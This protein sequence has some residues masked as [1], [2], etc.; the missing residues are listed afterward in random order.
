MSFWTD[1]DFWERFNTIYSELIPEPRPVRTAIGAALLPGYLVE[2]EMWAAKTFMNWEELITTDF[3]QISRNTPV[4]LPIAAIEQ[5]GPH[6]PL[7]TDR[8]IAQH[9]AEE[10][11]LRLGESVLILPTMAVGYSQHHMSF[12]GSLTLCHE[13]LLEVANEYLTSRG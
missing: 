5:H 1:L 2:L 11:N 8:L 13:T 10:L 3:E 4:V 9:F 12:T 7:A 6:L